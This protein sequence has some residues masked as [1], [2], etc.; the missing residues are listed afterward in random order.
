MKSLK[1]TAYK[2]VLFLSL[3]IVPST[4]FAQ[5]VGE[6]NNLV[7][8]ILA[9]LINPTSFGASALTKMLGI[10]TMTVDPHRIQFVYKKFSNT[11]NN[12]LDCTDN[13]DTYALVIDGQVFSSTIATTTTIANFYRLYLERMRT[14]AISQGM[15]LELN[16]TPQATSIWANHMTEERIKGWAE[17]INF[18][19]ECIDS[20]NRL[21]CKN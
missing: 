17:N 15:K 6:Y 3:C 11:V 8:A 4:A 18:S 2:T 21:A 20:N 12:Y 1:V 5:S 9:K 7:G 16:L 19:T 10:R 13:C 14:I